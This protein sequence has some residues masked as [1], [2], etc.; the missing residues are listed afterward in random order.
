[1]NDNVQFHKTILEVSKQVDYDSICAMCNGL[2][3]R[4]GTGGIAVTIKDEKRLAKHLNMR[5]K[6]FRKKYVNE[7]NHIESKP[8][9]MWK[10]GCTVYDA[11]PQVCRTFPI[12]NPVVALP[13]L[14]GHAV[15]SI[16]LHRHSKGNP[17]HP[18]QKLCE[19]LMD[20][21]DYAKEVIERKVKY[22]SVEVK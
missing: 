22:Q 16:A 5:H 18:E 13:C 6:V 2:C 8:C 1:M 19:S 10:D 12:G 17:P 14:A 21:E 9:P 3:C 4:G 20:S 15:L 11:R 7:T